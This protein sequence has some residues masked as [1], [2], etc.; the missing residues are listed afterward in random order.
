MVLFY[1]LVL[2]MLIK[3]VP[4]STIRRCSSYI[5]FLKFKLVPNCTK[6]NATLQCCKHFMHI[7][8][9]KGSRTKIH[10]CIFLLGVFLFINKNL[11]FQLI[12]L[13]FIIKSRNLFFIDKFKLIC[14]IQF[15]FGEI[16]IL[17]KRKM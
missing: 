9:Q 11:Y 3:Y 14:N 8:C 17:L 5:F 1:A 12:H 4:N 7:R 15:S 16:S 2:K 10:K 6:F 13:D